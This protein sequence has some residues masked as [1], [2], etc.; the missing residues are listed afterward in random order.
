MTLL[1][2]QNKQQQQQQKKQVTTFPELGK[3]QELFIIAM[4]QKNVVHI[5]GKQF[6]NWNFLL[7]GFPFVKVILAEA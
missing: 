4:C 7:G 1:V 6:I 2:S 5:R 3:N